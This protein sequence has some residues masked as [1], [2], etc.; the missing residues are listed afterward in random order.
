MLARYRK[1]SGIERCEQ[2]LTKGN[3][4]NVRTI[5]PYLSVAAQIQIA[6]ISALGERGFRAIINNRPDNETDDQPLSSTLAEEA[7]RHDIAYLEIPVIAG[8]LCAADVKAFTE[9]MAEIR[10][11]VLAFCRTGTR[12][13]T[14]WALYAAERLDVDAI[15]RTTKEAGYELDSLRP[16]LEEVA[17]I[18]TAPSNRPAKKRRPAMPFDVVIV[19][20]GSAG[21]ATAA[22]LLHRRAELDIAIIEPRQRHFY[23]P[24]FTLVGGGVFDRSQVVCS[25]ADVIP[26]QVRWVKTAAAGFEPES[27][28]VVLED[29]SHISYRQLVVAPGIKLDW[30]AVPGLRDTLGRNGVTSNYRYDLTSYTWDLVKNLRGGRAVFTQPPMPIKCAG[31]PQKAM[32]LSCDHWFRKGRLDDIQVDF[33]NAGGVLFGVDTYVP[34]LMEY[35]KKY[36]AKLNFTKNLVEIDGSAKKAWFEGPGDNGTTREAVDFDMIHVC[37]P[38]TAPD[39]IRYS[40]LADT[41]GWIDV[42]PDTLRHVNYENVFGLGDGTNTPNAK[43]M[44]AARKQAPVVAQNIVAALANQEL[45]AS[46]DGYGSCPLTV[47]KG[48]VILAEFGYGGKLL[49]SFPLW[50]NNGTQPTRLAWFLKE[51]LLPPI[52]YKL[53]LKGREW[54]SEP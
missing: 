46:Y 30:D 2:V 28:R 52:Y 33:F 47:E 1:R 54:L 20:G 38:Q 22:S 53:M 24:G 14:L 44:A 31:A 4:V 17:A 3:K 35:V 15:L 41:Q 45:R 9:A 26:S 16:R 18:G 29:G 50:L 11:P 10:G 25:T 32:Y 19:G 23:Q 6:D 8:K 42:A 39:F 43:T 21:I 13:A 5:S 7:K 48:K 12:S 36:D 27:N 49:P 34:A 37:P 40:P 51:R